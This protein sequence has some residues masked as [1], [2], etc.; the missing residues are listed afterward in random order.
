MKRKVG[1]EERDED[2]EDEI[3]ERR[4][5]VQKQEA[6]R[7]EE[8]EDLFEDHTSS[9][10]TEEEEEPS[11]EKRWNIGG[12]AKAG[13]LLEI[14]GDGTDYLYVLEALSKPPP[15]PPQEEAPKQELFSKGERGEALARVT[16][17]LCEQYPHLPKDSLQAVV[18]GH[19]EQKGLG[20]IVEEVS[21]CLIT[22]RDYL[23]VLQARELLHAH[24]E[25][26]KIL[27]HLPQTE[28]PKISAVIACAH[29]LQTPEDY[30]RLVRYTHL[31]R[32]SAY[33][34]E[35]RE[36]A[37]AVT[38]HLSGTF[39]AENPDKLETETSKEASAEK[40]QDEGK[41]E[42]HQ[43]PTDDPLGALSSNKKGL[44]GNPWLLR[45]AADIGIKSATLS[46]TADTETHT[47]ARQI[48]GVELLLLRALKN[49][50]LAY[51]ITL[52]K[53]E[54]YKELLQRASFGT[55]QQQES[56]AASVWHFLDRAEMEIARRVEREMSRAAEQNLK[57]TVFDKAVEYMGL[58]N[59]ALPV[60]AIWLIRGKFKYYISDAKDGK[61]EEGFANSNEELPADD[62][63]EEA[64][65]MFTGT[66]SKMRNFLRKGNQVYVPEELLQGINA[67]NKAQALAL[68]IRNPVQAF[69]HI[70]STEQHIP[71]IAPFQSLLGKKDALQMFAYAM[72]C[73]KA[74]R[75]AETS[76]DE[77]YLRKDLLEYMKGGGEV[78]ALKV[79]RN[80]PSEGVR[81][82]V[83]ETA[84]P[85]HAWKD[86]LRQPLIE[87]KALLRCYSHCLHKLRKTQKNPAILLD[88][89]L[90]FQVVFSLTEQEAIAL[91]TKWRLS[92][93]TEIS[94]PGPVLEGTVI[95][96]GVE[97]VVQL[98]NGVTATLLR[99]PSIHAPRLLSGQRLN[100]RVTDIDMMQPKIFVCEVLS[101]SKTPLRASTHWQFREM[102]ARAAQK[103]LSRSPFGAFVLRPS[104]THRDSLIL[105]IRITDIPDPCLCAHVRIKEERD[106]YLVEGR[107]VSSI[108]ELLQEY[109]PAY[110]KTA[111]HV[112]MHDHFS[113]QSPE[114]TKQKM[115]G[116]YAPG[117]P[118]PY[119]FSASQAV[120]GCYSLV[121][122]PGEG[123]LREIILH[124]SE[125]GLVYNGKC[126]PRPND[127]VKYIEL[128]EA[129]KK[130]AAI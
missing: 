108:D 73:H 88:P 78:E 13:I 21:P 49:R 100:T 7:R 111:K 36:I 27:Q 91:E 62:G 46:I 109:V 79:E 34:D 33:T 122:V 24:G 103:M 85:Q 99:E 93:G 94:L 37:A 83:K 15:L 119:A 75:K 104:S 45:A 26:K 28:D 126:F 55:E 84:A 65:H 9:T 98:D 51:K 44:V 17:I 67:K 42:K 120:P 130:E 12:A 89:R 97:T 2:S 38:Q 63:T 95:Y 60:R 3:V 81:R 69:Q 4:R 54:I 23:G 117:R 107:A 59:T 29:I 113:F 43:S 64:I 92:S 124:I 11:R 106:A 16:D 96:I 58:Q 40:A 20:E 72:E 6:E 114:K 5:K 70:I 129:R 90:H 82:A 118:M 110:L 121:F 1:P 32:S 86:P 19:I 57:Q 22:A 35:E 56:I 10:E 61:T 48:S 14:F 116:A 87:N 80:M 66:G 52:R 76:T 8:I 39:P 123:K 115:L 47:P 18:E 77:L 127:V 31:L 30:N 102:N 71:N 74:E 53:E 125:R 41:K 112:L 128:A 68:F 101:A 50:G 25:K 105:T